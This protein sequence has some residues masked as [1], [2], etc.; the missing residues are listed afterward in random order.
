MEQNYLR[1]KF[2]NLNSCFCKINDF[3]LAVFVAYTINNGSLTKRL[4]D[5]WS[6]KR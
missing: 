1:Q 6:K 2:E 5:M 4:L 3:Q